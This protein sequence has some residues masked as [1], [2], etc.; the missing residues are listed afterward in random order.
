M[1][2]HRMRATFGKLQSEALELKEGLNIIQAPNEAGKSTWCTFLLAMF[3]G[4]NSRERDR[5]D[6]TAV[7]KRYAPWSGAAMN[8][9]LACTARGQDIL[10]SRN[11][12]RAD[13]PMGDFRAVYAGTAEPV[14]DLTARNCGELLLGV[15]REV[16]ER[17]AFIRQA[18]LSIGQNTELER[19]I[20]SLI[21]SGEEDTSYTEASEALKKQLHRRRYHKSGE[22]PK[23]ERELAETQ[24]RLNQAEGLEARLGQSRT[25]QE[26]LERRQSALEEELAA[27]GR[28]E[29][30]QAG[31]AV[32]E[33]VHA[34]AAAEARA[35]A[36]REKMADFPELND[37]ARLRGAIVKMRPVVKQAE[38]AE[39]D[40]REAERR[41]RQAEEAVQRHVFAGKT[42]EEAERSP[43]DLP[44]RPRIPVWLFA[45]LGVCA[46]AFLVLLALRPLMPLLTV[47]G[48]LVL[49]G[50]AAVWML[51]RKQKNWDVLLEQREAQRIEDLAEY[52]ILYQA[53]ESARA[54]AAQQ[55]D[56]AEALG[57]TVS[58]N[59]GGILRE[60]RRFAPEAD[61]LAEAD[62]CLRDCALAW[63]ELSAAET[64]AR[65]AELKRDLLSRQSLQAAYGT[66]EIE[67]PQRSR[68][69]AET[70]L[71]AVRQELADARSQTDRLLGQLRSLGEAAVLRSAAQDAQAEIDSLEEEY[72]AIA[73]AMES[74]D[75]ANTTLHNRFSP[76]LGQR[77]FQIFHR[78]TGGRYEGVT[79]DRSFQLTVRDGGTDRGA[80]ALS[81]GCLDQLYLAVR[82]AICEMVLPEEDPAPLVL[83]DALANFDDDRCAAAVEYLRHLGEKRQI[84]LFTCHSR[85]NAFFTRAL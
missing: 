39:E 30:A 53:M 68:Q 4:I 8:G 59:E 65:E 3:Y 2:I 9:E 75:H 84:L 62:T 80:A 85:E 14:P 21:T 13:R 54:E 43:L 27:I 36:L 79:M 26:A 51:Y 46:A 40:W 56:Q 28:W 44:E 52:R 35:A 11:T 72:A 41:R 50:G 16:Y 48:A 12:A 20:A 66:D 70:E 63:K 18:G 64:A 60:V 82:L 45:V 6:M 23:M 71:D 22:I 19:R 33:A 34:A 69:E 7:K 55:S 67:P 37:I 76:A 74:L 73:L 81:A 61:T 42:P 15:K 10:I 25:E 47:D 57:Q 77:A 5:G 17:S 49:C 24:D 38:R 58:D 78:L 83:D 1:R 32:T 31:Q 29:A